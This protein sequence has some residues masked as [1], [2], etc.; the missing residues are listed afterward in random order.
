[1][2]RGRQQVGQHRRVDRRGV[3]HH[4][5]RLR[6]QRLQGASEEPASRG[7]VPAGRH[8]HVDDLPVL[9]NS[10][11][12]VPPDTVDLDIGLVD[13][14]AVTRRVAGEPGS[15]GQQRGEPLHPP[16]HGD[17]IGLDTAFGEQFLD[18]AVRQVVAQ[19]PAHRHH[20]H[21]RRKPEPRERRR[22]RPR[23]RPSG[24]PHR[25]TVP[26]RLAGPH[27]GHPIAQRNSAR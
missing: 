20:D 4:L 22:R 2:P 15:V 10:P 23:T 7:S 26:E 13:E 14:P 9:V 3:G 24:R 21:L 11:V 25:S 5:D 6:P 18:V 17:V 19:V 27:H 1:M 16:V 8:Q 12:H